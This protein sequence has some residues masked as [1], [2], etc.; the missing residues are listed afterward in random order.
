M[1]FHGQQALATRPHAD[2][3]RL[4]DQHPQRRR[5]M[6][7][8]IATVAL[9][10]ALVA[11]SSARPRPRPNDVSWAAR[12]SGRTRM[13]TFAC[14]CA[15][16]PAAKAFDLDS[17]RTIP[18]RPALASAACSRARD[19]DENGSEAI[20]GYVRTGMRARPDGDALIAG[21][22]PS[23]RARRGTLAQYCAPQYD[24]ADLQRVYCRD[25]VERHGRRPTSGAGAKSLQT[26]SRFRSK[27]LF[28][29]MLLIL[30]VKPAAFRTRG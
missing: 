16:M 4:M 13:R 15:A 23:R 3:P 18:K 26:G 9:A 17:N 22:N 5:N 25:R 8:L 1:P 11:R 6:K 12:A 27:D 19:D 14:R 21:A 30:S 2:A 29:R 10:T 7:T 24:P 20:C 28:G